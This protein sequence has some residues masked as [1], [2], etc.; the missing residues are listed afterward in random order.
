MGLN[1]FKSW[2]K[3]VVAE[4]FTLNTTTAALAKQLD[5]AG[6]EIASLQLDNGNL[7]REVST[8]AH[9]L[10]FNIE[11]RVT[12]LETELANLTVLFTDFKEQYSLE[13]AATKKALTE[14]RKGEAP[15]A[16]VKKHRSV[17]KQ[18]RNDGQDSQTDKHGSD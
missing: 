3:S 17:V 8:L 13:L 6:E 11:R 5:E 10:R 2:I 4:D 9:S 16:P 12:A 18:E 14:L 7:H 15:P 1:W